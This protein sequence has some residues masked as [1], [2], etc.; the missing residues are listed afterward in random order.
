MLDSIPEK[1]HCLHWR[2]TKIIATLGPATKS[3]AKITQLIE[4]GAN[5]FR[6]NMSH[7]THEEHELMAMRIRKIA[8]KKKKHIAILMDLCG[9]KI[10][11]GEF[12]SGSIQLVKDQEV[13]VSCSISKG[14][15]GLI[16]SQYKSLYKDVE[17]NDRILLD[18][19]KLE[20]TVKSVKDKDVVCRVVYGG[21]LKNKKGLNLPDSKV[22]TSSF[23]AKD[24][25]DVELAIKVGA[26]FLALSFV[27]DD[28]CIKTLKRYMKKLGSS[29]PVISKI[30]K[31]QAID[32][33]EE[34]LHESDG[35]MVAR[36]DLGIE[37]PAQQVPLLQKHLINRARFHAKPVIVATQ[38]LESMIT[39]SKPTRAEVGDVAT[40][41]LSS[42]DA[43]MLSAE[44]ASG[45]YPVLAIEMMDDILREMEAYQWQLGKFGEADFDQCAGL[46]EPDR[47]AVA[48]AVKTL[49]HELKLQGI[50]VPTRSGSTAK[51]L[52]ADRPSSP[53]IGISSNEVVCR[54]L[55]L[56]WGIVP[57]YIK[58][59]IT[60]DWQELCE[61]VS[62]LCDLGKTGN[63]VLLVSGFS[64]EAEL[65]E[66]VMKLMRINSEKIK[67]S[68]DENLNK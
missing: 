3:E 18:D 5:I 60:H 40:A 63:R 64:S 32:Y 23:T 8:K 37:L 15:D 50:M 26:D 22:S 24:K 10:R 54:R 41:A 17:K 35:I 2:R 14:S 42:A 33:I 25:R 56:S 68:I 46:I 4:A 31:P 66:P 20:L 57:I 53:L 7:G 67:R 55:A 47:K 12:E 6:L 30:E 39:N 19:G 52:S 34:I 38:M 16:P 36:G 11:V 49:S 43:V 48:R 65:N 29:I 1:R 58:E 62:C 61:N 9:P 59:E 51:I 21:E 27:R 28:K 44:T 45:D 13:V